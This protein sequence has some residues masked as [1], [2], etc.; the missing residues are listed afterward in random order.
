MEPPLKRPRLSMFSRDVAPDETLSRARWRNDLSLK[1][2][3]EAIFAKYAHDFTGVGDEIE[4]A[5]GSVVVNNGHLEAME[6]EGDTGVARPPSRTPLIPAGVINGGSLL[7]AMTAAP[8]DRGLSFEDIHDEDVVMSIEA[9]AENA[10]GYSE[11]DDTASRSA[12]DAEDIVYGRAS[13][14]VPAGSLAPRRD[15]LEEEVN[16]SDEELFQTTE[17]ISAETIDHR[18]ATSLSTGDEG[19]GNGWVPNTDHGKQ[20][21]R[22]SDKESDIMVKQEGGEYWAGADL[23]SGD[24]EDDRCSSPDSLFEVD[25]PSPDFLN[26]YLENELRE[27]VYPELPSIGRE[28]SDDAI[29][30]RFGPKIGP[31]VID[32][33]QKR[34]AMIDAHIEPAWRLPDIGVVF[35]K[36]KLETPHR[37]LHLSPEP[38][39]GRKDSLWRDSQ[40]SRPALEDLPYTIPR[41]VRGSSQLSDESEDPLQ[42]D[43]HQVKDIDDI[44]DA[45]DVADN[46]DDANDEN[47]EVVLDDVRDGICP[48]CRKQFSV[49]GS[50]YVH[51]DELIKKSV[52]DD[53]H[54]MAYIR[55]Q[56]RLKRHRTQFPKVTVQDFYTIIKL[57][58]VDKLDWQEIHD[59]RFF[60]QRPPT[61]LQSIHYQ[62]RT[63]AKTDEE[64]ADERRSWTAEEDARLLRFCE[65]PTMTFQKLR[66]T[67]R[68]RTQA[69]LGNRLASIWM[70]EYTGQGLETGSPHIKPYPNYKTVRGRLESSLGPGQT[71]P[72]S[73]KLDRR[74][75]SWSSDSMDSLF[76]LDLDAGGNGDH[77]ESD[78]GLFGTT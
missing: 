26:G 16:Y 5:T 62:Y 35:P 24:R 11:D 75:R 34:R 56:R 63:L 64:L 60:R 23:L 77:S 76:Q 9:M 27:P 15:N 41:R 54:D 61:S 46:L 67:M 58:E 18:K 40:I 71:R 4:V 55:H 69:E 13:P 28:V 31:Q 1:S 51:W 53:V 25:S 38:S 6:D 37:D 33:L 45:A 12:G 14:V 43:F 17:N 42:E 39:S 3:F 21:Y 68:T 20:I 73:L 2:R 44:D 72:A 29:L 49:T 10:A 30:D 7:R 47:L 52:Q 70:Q 57:R 59:R 36:P 66:K 8:E 78:D 19:F 22:S 65:D 32:V 48:F 74:R 50:V